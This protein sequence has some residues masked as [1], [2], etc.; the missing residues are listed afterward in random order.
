MVGAVPRCAFHMPQ[1]MA[2][3][4]ASS[5]CWG[6]GN[7]CCLPTPK[8]GKHLGSNLLGHH[9]LSALVHIDHNDV[10]LCTDCLLARS[11]GTQ[12]LSAA[13]SE[14]EKPNS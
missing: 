7:V 1:L 3:L 13:A 2:I 11:M 9:S 6:W 5:C 10:A 4:L 12:L 14:W 8:P